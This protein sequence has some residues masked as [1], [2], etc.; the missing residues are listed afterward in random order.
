[1][2]R[3]VVKK[4]K[5]KFDGNFWMSIFILTIMVLSIVGFAMM[6]GNYGSKGGSSTSLPSNL[7]LQE[8]NQNGEVF[9]GAIRNNEQFVFMNIEG[10]DSNLVMAGLAR[11]IKSQSSVNV[12]VDLGFESSDSLYVVEKALR[13]L[14]IDSHRVS[15]SECNSNTLVFTNNASFEGDCMKFI[16]SNAE[17]YANADVLVYHLVK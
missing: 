2:K 7:D 3:D 16:S 11:R 15:E 5:V 10:Y 17:A 12:Y 4:K 8:F 9:W 13:G 14:K 6:S 1:M